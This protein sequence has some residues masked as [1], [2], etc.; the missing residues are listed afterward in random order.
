[1]FERAELRISKVKENNEIIDIDPFTIF[2]MFNRGLTNSNRIK[3]CEAFKEVFQLDSEVP[4]EFS[5][6]PTANNQSVTFFYRKDERGIDD[7]NN[8]WELFE[9]AILFF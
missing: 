8:L 5:G 1:M 9:N 6:I 2:A 7:I 4:T 3:L